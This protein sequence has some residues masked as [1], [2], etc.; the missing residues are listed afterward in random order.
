LR[1][2]EELTTLQRA[3]Q[4]S[5][6]IEL[7]AAKEQRPKPGGDR[8]SDRA[9]ALGNDFPMV[10][11]QAE[12]AETTGVTEKTVR[13]WQKIGEGITEEAREVLHETPIA[14]ALNGT[15]LAMRELRCVA[16]Q[17]QPRSLLPGV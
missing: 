9:K 3:E 1:G 16:S 14:N 11:A 12:I 5:R 8:Q 15:T 2:R 7:D 6:L 17:W 4:T 10:T 13:N